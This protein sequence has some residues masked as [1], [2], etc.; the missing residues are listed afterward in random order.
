MQS[1]LQLSKVQYGLGGYACL[2]VVVLGSL[3]PVRVFSYELFLG[4]HVLGVG[5]IGAIA[6]HTP[7]AMRYFLAGLVCYIL[8]FI[9]V[10]FVKTFVGHARCEILPEGC[11]K[12]SIRLGSPMKTHHIGQHINLCIPALSPFQW[13]PFTITSVQ[14]TNLVH[15]NSIEVCVIA[16]GNFTR[17]LYD[18]V[19][20]NQE[21]S[22]FVSGPFGSQSIGP[23]D[24]LQSHTSVVI[25]CGGAGVTFGM[26]LLR[27]LT[28]TLV[29]SLENDSTKDIYFSWSVRRP[30]ELEWFREELEQIHCIYE[31]HE[32]FPNLHIQLHITSKDATYESN[33][34]T[35]ATHASSAKVT[36][37]VLTLHLV[38]CGPASFNASFKNTVAF[39]KSSNVY[40]HCEDFGY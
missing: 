8:N 1:E 38:L 27:E 15:Q 24:V 4:T 14:Q 20:P 2:C 33:A 28:D 16:R 10:W 40:L 31:T 19:D 5:F 7:Y 25:A 3:L 29:M 35:V 23:V 32:Q 30:L 37:N 36:V 26:R 9:A 6:V 13:H 39:Y 34:P 12:L 21:L 18:K 17:T 11:T 22:V